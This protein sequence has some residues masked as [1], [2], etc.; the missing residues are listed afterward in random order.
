MALTKGEK[1]EIREMLQGCM[2]GVHARTEAKFE[3]IEIKLN[4]ILEQTTKTNGRVGVLE[5]D[6]QDFK[7]H[8]SSTNNYDNKI[9]ALEDNQLS[10]RSIKKWI[11]A[12]IAITGTVMGIIFIVFKMIVGV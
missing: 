3:I 6:N 1:E 8:V 7:H 11:A 9:R 4:H 5:K 10:Q 2:S 12:S